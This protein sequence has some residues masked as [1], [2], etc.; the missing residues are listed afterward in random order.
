MSTSL[1]NLEEEGEE[2]YMP[3]KSQSKS[4]YRSSMK[5]NGS[6][7]FDD[8][9]ENIVDTRETQ[10]TRTFIRNLEEE[11]EESYMSQ[12]IFRVRIHVRV[13]EDVKT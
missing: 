7:F 6:D 11:G 4:I 8:R 9:D 10:G 13:C 1:R 3:R 2:P 12:N 5:T